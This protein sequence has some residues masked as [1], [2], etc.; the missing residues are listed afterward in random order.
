MNEKKTQGPFE[1]NFA[2]LCR[3]EAPQWFRD[4]KLGI[5]SHWGPQS[6]PMY[7]DWYARNMYIEGSDQYLYHLRRYGH[8]S[9]VG[10]KDIVKLWN[11]ERFDPAG[12]MRLYKRAGAKYFAAQ[13]MHH[14]NFFNYPSQINAWNAANVGPHKD[15]VGLWQAAARKEG[16]PFGLTEHMGA[17]FSWWATNKGCDREGPCMNVPY[18]GNDPVFEG[19]YLPNREHYEPVPSEPVT[20]WYTPNTWWHERWLSVMEELVD[21]YAPDLLYSDGALP[22]GE[23]RYGSGLEAV[24]H[25]YNTSAA[26][27]GGVNRAVYT[28]KD[29][30]REIYSVGV[31][32]VE[33]TQEADIKPEPWQ[34]DTCLGN[35]FYDVR[36][37]YKKPGHVVEML[38][39]I[40]SKNGNLLLNVPQKPDGTIDQECGYILEELAKWNA[41]CGEG[42]FGTRPFRISGEGSSKVVIDGFREDAVEWNETDLRFTTKGNT[43]YVFLMR[44]HGSGAAAIHALTQGENAIRVRLLGYGAVPFERTGG[45]LEVRLPEQAPTPYTNCLAIDLEKMG[46]LPPQDAGAKGGKR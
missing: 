4:A 21:R 33:R 39:D 16:L 13:A 25:L 43:V 6:V 40:V 28:Q 29:R 32:D 45:V 31:L 7:G 1:A 17:S 35:W 34:T 27:H 38:I 8:P 15:I 41:V 36:A 10:Y 14:D 5:W 44:W 26:R 22:F 9:R 37:R 18:D 46:N 24:A 23:G 3:F 19:F 11:A 2:S 42:I 30:R 20:P 12:L